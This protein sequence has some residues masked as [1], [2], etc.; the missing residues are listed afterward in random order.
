MFIPTQNYDLE[1]EEKLLDIKYGRRKAEGTVNGILNNNNKNIDE[2]LSALIYLRMAVD[3][4]FEDIAKQ[5]GIP[6]REEAQKEAESG[7][8]NEEGNN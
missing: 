1:F 3:T 4:C 2:K 7:A 6:T 8:G 5:Q